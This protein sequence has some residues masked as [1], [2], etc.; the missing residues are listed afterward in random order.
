MLMTLPVLGN[1]LYGW[2]GLTQVADLGPIAERS[3]KREGAL[4]WTY[5]QGGRWLIE[6][7]G[8]ENAARQ[9]ADAMFAPSRSMLLGN[10]A[11]AMYTLHRQSFGFQHRL[12]LWS[13]WGAPLLLLLT[14]IAYVR[15][16]K[17]VVTTRRLR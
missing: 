3:A 4:T 15:R 16:Q 8:L 17:Q 14:A 11:L 6:R 12:L 5:M 10:P 9:H 13:H 2:G 1:A 7:V